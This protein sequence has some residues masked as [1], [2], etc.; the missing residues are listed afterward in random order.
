LDRFLA[1]F[2][3]ARYSN[4][5]IGAEQRDG[6]VQTLQAIT[7]GIDSAIGADGL[8]SRTSEF[9]SELHDKQTK[10]GEFVNAEGE[11]THAGQENADS[12]SSFK[13]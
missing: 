1:I 12:G 3:E 6:A 8:I 11:V 7:M 5:N 4:H 13:I 10:A 9:E 2:E